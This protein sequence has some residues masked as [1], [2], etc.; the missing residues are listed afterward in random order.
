M[1][2]CVS[3]RACDSIYSGGELGATGCAPASDGL[4]LDELASRASATATISIP[5]RPAQA[6]DDDLMSPAPLAIQIA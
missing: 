5:T 4:H 1:C 2:V 3:E 6:A